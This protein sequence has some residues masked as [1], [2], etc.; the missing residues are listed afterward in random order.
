MAETLAETV[1]ETAELAEEAAAAAVSQLNMVF[2]VLSLILAVT[3]VLALFIIKAKAKDI[4]D[5]YIEPVDE[6]EYKT[7]KLLPIGLY[8]NNY[9]DITSKLPKILTQ[10]L[11]KR[12]N[13]VRMMIMELKDARYGDYYFTIFSAEKRYMLFYL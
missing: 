8:I 13:E 12:R 6:K 11:A 3:L 2:T 5:E 10:L 9:I 4:Y 1:T 7:K